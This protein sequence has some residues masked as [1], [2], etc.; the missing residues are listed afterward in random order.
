MGRNA[1]KTIEVR[2]RVDLS[3][4]NNASEILNGCGLNMS[5]AIRLFLEQV[6]QE[7]RLP[8]TA[9]SKRPSPAMKAA[10]SEAKLIKQH[11]RDLQ[12]LL[13]DIERHND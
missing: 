8:F 11:H 7:N 2:S 4:K 9:K 1:L 5:S 10:L 13:D 6:V 3:L 12:S